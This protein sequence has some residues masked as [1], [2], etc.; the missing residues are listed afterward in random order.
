MQDVV[1]ILLELERYRHIV[2]E[3]GERILA[4]EVVDIGHVASEEIVDANDPVRL[5][6][7]TITKMRPQ[8]TGAT[9]DDGSRHTLSTAFPDSAVLRPR[10]T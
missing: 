6:E 5:G 10:E 9:G 4:E 2:L 3:E 8:K 1:D 7:E